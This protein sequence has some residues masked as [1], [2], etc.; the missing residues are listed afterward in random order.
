MLLVLQLL[1]ILLLAQRETSSVI[2]METTGIVRL[3]RRVEVHYPGVVYGFVNVTNNLF[4][5]K[6]SI[7]VW[8]KV[9]CVLFL[10]L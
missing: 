1:E 7:N 2:A 8:V 5:L 9:F 10:H 6:K 4:T 3:K